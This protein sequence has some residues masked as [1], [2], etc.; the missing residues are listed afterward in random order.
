MIKGAET[1]TVVSTIPARAQFME[2]PNLPIIRAN[3]PLINYL[4]T[5]AQLA[6]TQ[7]TK[8][9]ELAAVGSLQDQ[10]MNLQSHLIIDHSQATPLNKKIVR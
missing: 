9:L 5:Q 3:L 4:M 2:D 6:E 1:T 8:V 7:G 10:T